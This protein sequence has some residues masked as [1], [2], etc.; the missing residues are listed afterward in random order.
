MYIQIIVLFDLLYKLLYHFKLILMGQSLI[1]FFLIRF[2]SLI[3]LKIFSPRNYQIF[4][5]H[6]AGQHTM[7]LWRL[8]DCSLQN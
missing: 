3:F 2:F 4:I 7:F 5:Y 6:Y 1:L 8:Y